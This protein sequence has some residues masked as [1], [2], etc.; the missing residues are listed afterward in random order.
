MALPAGLAALLPP[1]LRAKSVGLRGATYRF[2]ECGEGR[3]LLL[4]HGWAGSWQNVIRWMP[5]LTPR[6]RLIVPD[7]PGCNGAPPLAGP[8]TAAAYADFLD[9]LCQALE[10]AETYVGGLTFGANVAA[11]LARRHPE[12]VSGLLLHTP[13]YHPRAMRPS[14]RVQMRLS[15]LAPLYAVVRRLRFDERITGLTTGMLGAGDDVVWEDNAINQKNMLRA[16]PRAAR[17]LARDVLRA[18]L[19][20][21]LRSWAKPLFVIVATEDA[22]IRYPEFLWIRELAPGCVVSLIEGGGHGWTREFIE[23]QERCLVDFVRFVDER[24]RLSAGG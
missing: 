20:G 6:F 4:V 5:V 14:F 3:S 21:F 23:R 7:L 1:A 17:E 18:D 9:E 10:I 2:V 24:A 22:V 15:A 12:R 11:E 16:D 19:V 13:L 8:H